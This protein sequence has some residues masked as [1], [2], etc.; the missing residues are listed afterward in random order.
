MKKVRLE[1]LN[2]SL[3]KM[4]LADEKPNHGAF[5]AV[6]KLSIPPAKPVADGEDNN[7]DFRVTPESHVFSTHDVIY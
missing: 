5:V 7:N 3:L 1:A 2:S 4:F 6:P